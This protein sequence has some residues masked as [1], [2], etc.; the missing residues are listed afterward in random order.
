MRRK[1]EGPAAGAKGQPGVSASGNLKE[2]SKAATVAGGTAQG[3][4][5]NAT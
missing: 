3:S 5:V 2:E 4:N 1:A